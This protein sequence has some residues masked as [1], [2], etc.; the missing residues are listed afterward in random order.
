MTKS[1]EAPRRLRPDD[2]TNPKPVY[3][4]WEITLRC[5]HACSHCGSRATTARPDEL[6]TAELLDVANQ[7]IRI[8][9]REVTLIGG[10]AYLRSDV[11]TLVNHLSKNGIYVAMQSGG[12]GLNKRRLQKLKDA[13]LKGIGISIDGPEYVH[14]VLRSRPGSWKAGMAAIQ[15]ARDLGFIITSN[16]QINQLSLPHLREVV[17]DVRKAG[18]RVWRAQITV[19]MGRAADRP[20][21]LLQPWQVL[22]L[23]DTLADLKI[24]LLQKAHDRGIP[25]NKVMNITMGNN[26][27]YYGPHEHLLRSAPGV[28]A[29]V[30]AG[31]QAGRFTLGIESDGRIKGC[32][33]LPTAPYIGG[34]IRDLTLEQIWN[35]TPELRFVRD[36]GTNEL[37]GHCKDCYYASV[38]K[39][40]CSFTTHCFFN[41]RGNNPFCYYRASKLQKQGRRERVQQ[42][43]KA[44]G[45]PYDF[46]AFEIIEESWP[47]QKEFS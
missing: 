38:C 7:L 27:G 33:S 23:I 24:E 41:K 21:W 20:E 47:S 8:G 45:I 19:P 44:P 42:V 5:D 22:E 3:A 30:W 17:D 31:C 16:T 1:K 32:P 46:G 36:R 26:V 12:L 15:N 10:E 2:F 11:Y 37:W 39:A 9:T 28:R 25:P 4:V 34:N 43:Q 6:S 35:D 13:G 40:G 29:K 18:V 14:D